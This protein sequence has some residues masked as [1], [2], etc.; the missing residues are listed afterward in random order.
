MNY[1]KITL[2]EA[3][4]FINTN[5]YID[6]ISFERVQK[7]AEKYYLSA[8]L[9]EIQ[10][11]CVEYNDS[12]WS[13]QIEEIIAYDS[14]NK[15]VEPIFLDIKKYREDDY[16]DERY[17]LIDGYNSGTENGGEAIIK[18]DIKNKQIVGN[19]IELYIKE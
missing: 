10:L 5:K 8:Q 7:F 15:K 12:G 4:K 14:E 2:E 6:I 13:V 11:N 1:R 19:D 3:Q 17:Y 16:Y 9:I 18:Y